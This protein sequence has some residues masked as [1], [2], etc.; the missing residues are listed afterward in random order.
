MRV[1]KI[2]A[3]KYLTPALLAAALLSSCASYP[4]SKE[5]RQQERQITL[6]EARANP[7]GTRGAVVIWGGRIINLTN[8]AH[9]GTIYI[10]CLPMPENERP[11]TGTPSPGRFIATSAHFLDPEMFPN[12]SLITVA[13]QLDGVRTEQLQNFPYPYPVLQIGETHVWPRESEGYGYYYPYYGYYPPYWGWWGP[14]WWWWGGPYYYGGYYYGGYHGG[15]HGYYGGGG[16]GG[17]HGSGGGGGGGFHGSSGGHGT[18]G[19]GGGGGR[20]FGG[21]GGG[22]GGHGR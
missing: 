16:G 14:D 13:G 7:D 19:G 2:N 3:V 21:G 18:S 6:D 11:L 17:F 1:S 12:G 9:G 22:G 8:D 4:I 20:G 5:Y 10:Y 15:Y